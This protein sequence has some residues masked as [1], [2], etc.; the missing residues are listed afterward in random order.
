MFHLITKLPSDLLVCCSGGVDSISAAH[1]LKRKHKVTL[2]HFNHSTSLA[3]IMQESVERFARDFGLEL[4]VKKTDK[5]LKKE[6]EFRAERIKF[7]VEGNY[8]V[9]VAHQLGD[10]CESFLSCALQ[11]KMWRIPMKISNSLGGSTIYRPFITTPK[12]KLQTYATRQGLM[13][14]VVE[15]TTN[16]DGSNMRSWLRCNMMPLLKAKQIGLQK[17]VLKKYLKYLAESQ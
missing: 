13:K 14:Y 15:D 17:V 5:V 10:A 2:Y 8:N 6:A 12:E 7:L 9:V 16:F 4:I 3:P 1:F 11:G